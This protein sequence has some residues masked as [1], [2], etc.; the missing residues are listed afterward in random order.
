VYRFVP[1]GAKEP[2]RLIDARRLTF[3]GGAKPQAAYGEDVI[4]FDEYDYETDVSKKRYF[5]RGGRRVYF[6]DIAQ[7]RERDGKLWYAYWEL[8][9]AKMWITNG[10]VMGV[11]ALYAKTDEGVTG[12][13]VDRHVEGLIVGKDEAKMGQNGS[14]T[15]ELSLQAVRVPR[16]NVIGL[17][18]RGQVNALETLNVGRAGLAMSAMSQMIRLVDWSRAFARARYGDI[19]EWIAWRIERME[20]E[21]F[22]TEALAYATIGRFEHKQTKSVRIESAV[23]KVLASELFHH[24]IELAEEIHGLAGQTQEYLIEKRKRD[25]RILNIYEGTNEIQRFLILKELADVASNWASRERQRP[26]DR[27]SKIEDRESRLAGG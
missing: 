21:R 19:P 2:R 3:G 10:R 7:L 26:K 12:F 27:G 9:G 16:E 1:F 8:T 4:H 24:S 13:I 6:D 22:I 20:E 15:N 11:M 25:A 5:V 14:P 17:E 18:G 23:A